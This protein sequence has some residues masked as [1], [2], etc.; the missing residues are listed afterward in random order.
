MTR[1]PAQA[2]LRWVMRLTVNGKEIEIERAMTIAEFLDAK[3]LGE[4]LAAVEHNG[5]WLRRE[6]WANVALNEADR[7]EIVRIM[8]GG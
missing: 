4:A 5:N 6:D 8:A 2:A 7:L 3:G 1:K